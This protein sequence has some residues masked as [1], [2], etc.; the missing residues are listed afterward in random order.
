MKTACPPK[1]MANPANRPTRSVATGA[2][3][4]PPH[5]DAHEW[6][7]D[8]GDD[9]RDDG[10]YENDARPI[11]DGNDDAGGYGREGVAVDLLLNGSSAISRLAL[12]SN[13]VVRVNE[14]N[15]CA[16]ESGQNGVLRP[17]AWARAA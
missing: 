2:G 10:G 17:S 5:E 11:E 1:Y 13:Y 15:M 8:E 6:F 4:S 14:T 16:G 9:D 7:E 12:R 3:D